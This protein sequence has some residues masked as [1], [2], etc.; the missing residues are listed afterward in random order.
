MAG[1]EFKCATRP[2]EYATN[3]L[4]EMLMILL[5]KK[6]DLARGGV[7]SDKWGMHIRNTLG[8]EG[9]NY[10]KF[11]DSLENYDYENVK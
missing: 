7:D 8:E 6:P 4:M 11:V 2:Y 1:H 10:D 9:K 5:E 3:Y